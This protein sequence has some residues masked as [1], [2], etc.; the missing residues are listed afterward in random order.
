M[1]EDLKIMVVRVQ[2]D[3]EQIAKLEDEVIKFLDDLQK[4]V[5]QL[6]ALNQSNGVSNAS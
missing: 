2:R 1:P 3:D 4:K 5:D 6:T